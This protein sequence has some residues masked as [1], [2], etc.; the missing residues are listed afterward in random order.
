M[1]FEN[2]FDKD[3]ITLEIE[4]EERERE[5]IQYGSYLEDVRKSED[6]FIE[7]RWDT[8]RY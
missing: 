7:K 5:R 4:Q 6:I 1:D 2:E 3:N 8:I